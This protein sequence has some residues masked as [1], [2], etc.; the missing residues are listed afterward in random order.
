MKIRTRLLLLILPTV[1]GVILT[2]S[3]L[4]YYTWYQDLVSY[5]LSAEVINQKA[6]ETQGLILLGAISTVVLIMI[7]VAFIADNISQPIEQLKNAALTLA[8]G[9]Y[10]KKIEVKGP[11]EISDL[12]NTLNTMSE[13]LREHLTTVEENSMVREKMVGE[14]EAYRLLQTRLIQGIGDMFSHPQMRI[15]ALCI[16]SKSPQKAAILEIVENSDTKVA[17][18]LRESNF[19]SFDGFYELMSTGDSCSKIEA[20]LVADGQKWQLQTKR[21]DMPEPII[22]S[23]ADAQVILTKEGKATVET[24]DFVIIV[25]SSLETLIRS[26]DLLHPSF[27]RVFRHF[28]EEGLDACATLLTHELSFL[29][30]QQEVSAPLIAICLKVS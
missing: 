26:D 21:S 14:V 17:L 12:A 13:C 2:I 30:K 9:N 23:A 7:G 24:N 20:T 15:K 6:H 19:V 16:P 11:E 18:R 22:W 4:T 8:S 1:L 29:A 27:H 3:Y 28:A 5:N 25:N 10:G